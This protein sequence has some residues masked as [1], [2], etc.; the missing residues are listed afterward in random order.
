MPC[1]VCIDHLVWSY[2]YPVRERGRA[3]ELGFARH[4]LVSLL[5]M[6][7]ARHGVRLSRAGLAQCS[8]TPER[9]S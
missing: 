8:G 5:V 7:A 4:K 1:A 2:D 6:K 9:I 3:R